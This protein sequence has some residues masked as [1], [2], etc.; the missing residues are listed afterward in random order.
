MKPADQTEYIVQAI[1]EGASMYEEDAR[2]FLAEH[3]AHVR[4]EAAADVHRA[5]LPRFADGESPELVAKTVRAVDV[6]LAEDGPQAPYGVTAE[7]VDASEF[8]EVGRTYLGSYG[9]RFRV[10]VITTHPENGERA[11]LGWRFFNDV[12]EPIAYYEDD[13][14]LH[15]Y[16]GHVEAT[17][18]AAPIASTAAAVSALGALPVP[19]GD[20]PEAGGS[21]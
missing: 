2:A 7:V 8:F 11:A 1:R 12:W 14:D 9:W 5:E 20:E 19:I 13:W 3:D 4:A 10:D 6:R 15:Q 16:V 17:D 18:D 21:S